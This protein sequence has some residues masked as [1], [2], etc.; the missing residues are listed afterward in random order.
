MD[1]FEI[2]SKVG[3]NDPCP[4]G[5]GKKFKKCCIGSFR[6]LFPP[7]KAELGLLKS[8]FRKYDLKEIISTI[9]G[10]HLHPENHS[11]TV[12]LEVASHLACSLKH[13]GK[14]KIDP[15]RLKNKLNEYLDP[16]CEVGV[17]EDPPEQL[18]TE[19][20]E[21][22]GGNYIIY[23]GIYDCEPFV[24]RMLFKTLFL[25]ENEYPQEF[26]DT[27]YATSLCILSLSNE[28]ARRLN[29]SRYMVS[30]S[31]WHQNIDI[32]EEK[33]LEKYRCSVI[34]PNE[35]LEEL[36]NRKNIDSR[37][38]APFTISVGDS[39]F[40]ERD[41]KKNPLFIT[42]IVKFEDDIIVAHP[43]SLAAALR[44]FIWNISGNF[45]CRDI[46]AENY[47][48]SVFVGIKESL[49]LIGFYEVDISLPPKSDESSIEESVY[50]IDTD[51]LV[52]AVLICDDAKNYPTN[53]INGE[54]NALK[55]EEVIRS[56]ICQIVAYLKREFEH[57]NAVLV[58]R[59]YGKIGRNFKTIFDDQ[60]LLTL[61]I[62]ADELELLSQLRKCEPLTLWKFA[63]AYTNF[64]KSNEI[65]SWSF[66]DTFSGYIQHN[67]SFSAGDKKE[68]IS[69]NILA[70]TGRDLRIKATKKFDFHS[71][72]KENPSGFITVCKV[73]E[74][75]SDET[76]TPYY[77][78]DRP[79]VRLVEGYDQAIWIEP[80]STE[81]SPEQ[82]ALYTLISDTISY[83]VSQIKPS[84]KSLLSSTGTDP[85]EIRYELEDFHLWLNC[86]F[87]DMS[88]VTPKC[89]FSIEG[90]SILFSIPHTIV[91]YLKRPDN[92]GERI[93]LNSL[94]EAIDE[95]IIQSS[96][97]HVLDKTERHNI[98]EFYAPIGP[99][100][101]VLIA[102]SGENGL[103][104][105]NFTPPPRLLQMHDLEA[106]KKNL[107]EDLGLEF[108]IGEY[109]DKAEQ[110]K[111]CEKVVNTYLRR[112]RESL[113]QFSHEP[114]FQYLIGFHEGL[115]HYQ[116]Y[117]QF[118]T[119]QMISC[120]TDVDELAT[121]MIKD[122]PNIYSTALSTRVLIEI[123]AAE[124]PA[125]DRVVSISELDK[126]LALTYHLINWADISDRIRF[127]LVQIKI[128]LL[129]NGRI[130]CE[131]LGDT[132][133]DALLLRAKTLEG[134]ESALLHSKDQYKST[135][136]RAAFRLDSRY[137][138]AFNAE[139]GIS[140]QEAAQFIICLIHSCEQ[141][142][143]IEQNSP[144]LSL[145]LSEFKKRIISAL[146]WPE[147]RVIKAI[148]LFSLSPR[149]KW[150]LAP[151]GFTLNED[152]LPWRYN[153]RLSYLR[154]P[155]IIGPETDTEPMIFWGSLHVESS[156]SYLAELIDS[157]RYKNPQGMSEE[158]QKLLGEIKR[159][160][161]KFFVSKVCK[162]FKD[163]TEYIVD[164]NV[165]IAPNEKLDSTSNLGDI[166]VLLIDIVQ[167][168]I[169]SI[170]CK[171][172]NFGRNA[173]EIDNE[174][175]RFIIDKERRKSWA[176]KHI[177]RDEWLKNNV[178]K[179]AS[180]YNLDSNSYDV[181]S[182]FMLSE[183]IFTS[184]SQ[185]IP[186]P[187]FSYPQLLRDG[188]KLFDP[189][190]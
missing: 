51:K 140:L 163:N 124:P 11:H 45:K 8:E 84:I 53:D 162:W 108:S 146:N 126:L 81:H 114:L 83:W 2:H 72:Q 178:K 14:D 118:S 170:E 189:L 100:K 64:A 48:K 116:A 161:G 171:N 73:S 176:S 24:L 158:M 129:G 172:I 56:R 127:D 107:V 139:V 133:F 164:P 147:D 109:S 60:N 4:C 122:L 55:L 61:S 149:E 28:I 138:T 177:D 160:N 145:P 59:V 168:K 130:R 13:G 152:I 12:R 98:I 77:R 156:F 95:F 75:E 115:L 42:P 113:T 76:Y 27:I 7:K 131:S 103:L 63:E 169:F 190:L 69:L 173:R 86:E 22:Y 88:D 188:V 180:A 38:L 94:L 144:T 166:D 16:F 25:E 43:S 62:C 137:D 174:I 150:D 121:E 110:M 67:H 70:G 101:K 105:Q 104:F 37:F 151:E 183:S 136:E 34:F 123:I 175:S 117:I 157:G 154:R 54:W 26:L 125:G 57:C 80:Q 33:L 142:I 90:R 66:L 15:D 41:T 187:T 1:I 106:Q 85:I 9:A 143:C 82:L 135:D 132:N 31:N 87:E 20:I 6:P 30:P 32:P 134:I 102:G 167:K 111:I 23:P 186:L 17:L 3:R 181:I 52:Y 50:Q 47:R 185:K 46:L 92:V 71:A 128:I 36:L 159:E 119:P 79:I 89:G 74:D 91:P 10:L 40:K 78:I 18:F 99:K 21:F 49:E 155:L 35:E 93:I 97:K 5:S 148:N 120:Y 68:P 96:G 141:F 182:I 184:I 153:R 112:I 58:L 165:P 44:H 29:Q 19:N 179:V 39:A 65:S